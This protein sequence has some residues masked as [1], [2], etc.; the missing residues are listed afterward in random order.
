MD[1]RIERLQ[2]A[3]AGDRRTLPLAGGLPAEELFPRRELA[4]AFERVVRRSPCGALQYGWPEGSEG[5]R[6]W[7]ADRLVARGA[8]VSPDDV[9]VT[10]GAQQAIAIACELLGVRGTRVAV[11]TRT[12]PG[13]LDLLRGR[14]AVVS[15]TGEWTYI[16]DGVS[17]PDG[18]AVERRAPVMG[19]SMI[20]A[21]E[22]YAEL[23]FDGWIDAPLIALAPDRVLHVGTLSKTLCPGFRVGWLV[24]PPSMREAARSAKRDL[25]LQAG[26]LAQAIVES[27]LAVADYDAH[28]ARARRLY[29]RRA[30][31]L[32][33]ALRRS[34]PGARFADPEGG[35]STWLETDIERVDEAHALAVAAEHGV[36]FDPGSLFRSDA[37]S[38]PLAMRL[39]CSSIAEDEIETAVARL[40][41]ALRALC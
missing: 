1:A 22:A 40:A 19:D 13:A 6:R 3:C 23:R 34:L 11:A 32:A 36:A 9:V 18:L 16:V 41:R 4:A 26:S 20:V 30:D 8:R 39:S 5:L 37:R 35:F 14:G 17:M 21:D 29:A 27:Y 7:I 24:T 12:Y 31:R 2:R 25:D 38:S 28:L 33:C 10:A 15:P